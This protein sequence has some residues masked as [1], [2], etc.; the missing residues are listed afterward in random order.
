MS[1][2]N[3]TE[4]WTQA[5]RGQ[6]LVLLQPLL[7]FV[8]R[9]ATSIFCFA[10]LL[11][12]LVFNLSLNLLC[13]L[14]GCSRAG[15]GGGGLSHS[16]SFLHSFLAMPRTCWHVDAH[17]CQM[18]APWRRILAR[19][20]S[21]RKKRDQRRDHPIKHLLFPTRS[22][23]FLLNHQCS[24]KIL[25]TRHTH[26]PLP[27]SPALWEEREEDTVAD[28]EERHHRV[29]PPVL[30]ELLFN[31]ATDGRWWWW[32]WLMRWWWHDF[33]IIMILL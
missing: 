10:W 19:A 9:S 4:E 13:H 24:K 26:S 32:W 17:T 2:H 8:P 31:P 25:D 30:S 21:H 18:D 23:R 14:L 28:S 27:L 1:I 7:I 29:S 33:K 20:G 15:Q 22:P 6:N 16:L 11:C 12:K 5:T 3:H